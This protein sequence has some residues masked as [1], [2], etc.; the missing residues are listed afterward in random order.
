MYYV[1]DIYKNREKNFYRIYYIK[2][3]YYKIFILYFCNFAT[4]EFIFKLKI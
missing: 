4:L 2:Y 3:T 1:H